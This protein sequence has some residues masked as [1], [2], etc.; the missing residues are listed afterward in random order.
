MTIRKGETWGEPGSL[1]AD[2]LVVGRGAEADLRIN[3]PGIS[4]RHAEFRLDGRQ[5]KVVDLGSTNGTVVDGHKV[6]ETTV[7]DGATVR[8]GNTDLVVRVG[9]A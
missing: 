9:G 6:R 3:D 2:G 1:P 8:L 7:R 5:V 4:R